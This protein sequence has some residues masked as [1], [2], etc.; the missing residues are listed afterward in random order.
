MRQ[1]SLMKIPISLTSVVVVAAAFL[2]L[3]APDAA[4]W[5][6]FTNQADFTNAMA[7]SNFTETFDSLPGND[8]VPTPT[9]F[10]GN[11]LSFDATTV[12]I[13]GEL[14]GVV[15]EGSH[16]LSIYD[17]QDSLVFTNF[18]TGVSAI[19][20]IFYV[21][22]EYNN[23]VTNE[24]VSFQVEL[25]DSSVIT[26]N[27]I[28]TSPTSFFGF[29]FNSDIRSL[30][31]SSTNHVNY[32]LADDVTIGFGRFDTNTLIAVQDGKLVYSF[33]A[34]TNVPTVA[35]TTNLQMSNSWTTTNVTSFSPIDL[36]SGLMR[37]RYE[38]PITG[39][40]QRFMRALPQP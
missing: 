30:V 3:L 34:G 14:Y 24:I 4:A 35:T 13:N 1:E 32:P 25:A 28:S 11:G 5:T 31:I 19:G 21:A 38:T 8:F 37:Y 27:V 26:T 9:N 10:S 39:D 33:V 17:P 29:V 12:K 36:G 15:S 2:G 20:G 6:F 40:T 16:R 22:N 7:S 23:W 18:S